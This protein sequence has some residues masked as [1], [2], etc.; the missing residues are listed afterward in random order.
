MSPEGPLGEVARKLKAPPRRRLELIEELGADAEALQKE[1]EG[2]GYDARTARRI[3]ARQ[4][5]PSGEVLAELEAQHAPRLGRWIQTA[6]LAGSIERV[7][8]T[9]AASLAGAAM[10]APLWRQD[11]GVGSSL[12]AWSLVV[13]VAL[14]SSNWALAAKRL[15]IDGYLRPGLRRVLWARQVGLIVAAVSLGGLGVSWEG[16]VALGSLEAS[17]GAVWSTVQRVVLFAVVAAG[18]ALFGLLGWVALIPRLATDEACERRI[19]AFVNRSR[20]FPHLR[21][22]AGRH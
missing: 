21:T 16:H 2:R 11:S 14:L 8:A 9:A 15:W 22:E 1:L 5:E 6:G 4:L 18:A 13:V 3:A 19:A 10:L 20:R 12:L 7:G 17:P